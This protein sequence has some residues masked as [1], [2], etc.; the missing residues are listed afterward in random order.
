MAWMKI[1][2]RVRTHPKIVAAGPAAAWFWFCGICYCREHLTDGFIPTGMLQ[3]LAP[4]VTNGRALAKKLVEVR[5]WHIAE[6]GYQVHDFTEWN[7]TRAEVEARRVSDSARKKRGFQLED[8]PSSVRNS[9]VLPAGIREDSSRAHAAAQGSPSSSSW[10][11]SD[12]E[13][14]LGET[15]PPPRRRESVASRARALGIVPPGPWERQH[16]QHALRGELCGWVCMPQAVHDEFVNRLTVAGH[17][18]PTAVT[19]VQAWALEVKARWAVS[20]EV[21]GD[22]IFKFW[23][24]EW[25]ATHGSNKPT[26]GAA[27]PLAG[28]RGALSRG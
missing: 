9:S 19:Q 27:D 18:W 7:Q 14:G 11:L 28:V 6:G 16:G 13:G 8:E 24:H 10:D 25:A 15:T 4:G 26:A 1:D 2:D 23:R 22:D 5:L 12:P 20:G 3:S 21:P 17:E